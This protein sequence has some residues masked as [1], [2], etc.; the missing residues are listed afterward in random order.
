MRDV[1]GTLQ[2]APTK[3]LDLHENPSRRDKVWLRIVRQKRQVAKYALS[4]P[5]TSCCFDGSCIQVIPIT[6]S[7]VSH[8]ASDFDLLRVS[9]PERFDQLTSEQPLETLSTD[10]M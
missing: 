2:I 4:Q 5:A 3:I 7:S 1:R 9:R 8:N 6:D 10:R